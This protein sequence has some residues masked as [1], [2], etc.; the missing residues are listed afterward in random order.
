MSVDLIGSL[1][2]EVMPVL[3]TFEEDMIR[4]H[5]AYYPAHLA[6]S[7]GVVDVGSKGSCSAIVHESMCP[8]V[9]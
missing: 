9:C 5:R 8:A 3:L 2:D 6:A 7:V 4:I 1:I